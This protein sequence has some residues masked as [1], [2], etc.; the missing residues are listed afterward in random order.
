MTA[1]KSGYDASYTLGKKLE[2]VPGVLNA[3]KPIL[4]A[5][6]SAMKSYCEQKGG[7]TKETE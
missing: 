2:K 4:T 6:Y 5:N 1:I 3:M 7:K